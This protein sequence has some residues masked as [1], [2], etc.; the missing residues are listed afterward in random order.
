M[1]LVVVLSSPRFLLVHFL[2]K[3]ICEQT[4]KKEILKKLEMLRNTSPKDNL[5]DHVYDRAIRNLRMQHRNPQAL[6]VKVLPW[7]VHVRAQRL[8]SVEEIR[9]GVSVEP[10]QRKT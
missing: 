4:K 9:F 10:G 1:F 5:L 2:I 3:Y 8:L 7:I 6:T